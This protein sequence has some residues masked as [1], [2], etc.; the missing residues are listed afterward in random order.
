MSERGHN[1]WATRPIASIA[2]GETASFERV[3]TPEQ[4]EAFAALSGDRNP[5]HVDADYARRTTFQKPVAH[6]MLV[7]AMVS[8]LIGMHLPGPGALWNQQSFRWLAPVFAG[9]TIKVEGRVTQVSHG[10]GT[11]T[12]AVTAVNQNGKKVMEGEGTV[13]LL[14]PREEKIEKAIGERVVLVSGGS[15]GIGA[16]TAL[17]FGRAGAMVAVNYLRR[18]DA[19]EALCRR[20]EE[21]G[22][23]AVAVQ[24]DVSASGDVRRAVDAAAEA[25]G[26]PVD[27]LVNNACATP[28]PKPFLET[29]WSDFAAL[30]DVQLRGAYHC[31][32]AVL[33]AMVA[34]GSGVIVNIGSSLIEQPPPAQWSAWV[35]AK[36]ALLGLTRTLAVEFG[37][38]GVRVNMVSPGATETDS[39]AAVPERLRKVQAMQTPLRRLAEPIDVARTVVFLCSEGGRFITGADVPVSGGAAA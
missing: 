6:G 22:G 29:E 24:A 32:R 33:P 38:K 18:E 13:M 26:R 12:I 35:S 5:L 28:E 30:L 37:P 2:V 15:R 27:V 23:R 3:I 25:F 8:T 20:I 4:I 10:A 11:L 19:A 34:Q 9:D 31:A 14:S 16:A 36:S 1:S 21:E 17:E 7:G 39:I